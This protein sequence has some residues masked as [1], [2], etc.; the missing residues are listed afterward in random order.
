M[1]LLED[2]RFPIGNVVD[3]DVL[4]SEIGL[5]E[6]G[7]ALQLVWS[8]GQSYVARTVGNDTEQFIGMAF[9]PRRPLSSYG[10]IQNTFKISFAGGTTEYTSAHAV[11]TVASVQ[12][13]SVW[14]VNADGSVT[15]FTPTANS[16]TAPASAG[17][18]QIKSLNTLDLIFY[19]PSAGAG[20][21]GTTVYIQF[22]YIPTIDDVQYDRGGS[23]WAYQ[24]EQTD[25]MAKVSVINSTY[26]ITTDK[27]LATGDWYNTP[28]N[29]KA[30]AGGYFGPSAASGTDISGI[31]L[32]PGAGY[33]RLI[34]GPQSYATDTT[35]MKTGI[36]LSINR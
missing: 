35:G 19:A 30:L 33:A 22:N 12:T 23:G 11:A 2:A 6:E 25:Y 20:D 4:P 18:V 36:T 34:R 21:D 8:Q 9:G 29:L 3:Y 28:G 14:K 24:G 10:V 7:M 32:A 1:I 26:R 15:Y 17:Q 13:V 5:I 27:F 31:G 16:S